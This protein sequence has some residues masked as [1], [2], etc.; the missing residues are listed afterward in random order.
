ME[1][2]TA[3]TKNV[4]R[5]NTKKNETEV[6]AASNATATVVAAPAETTT[7][8]KK[9]TSRSKKTE[10]ETIVETKSEEVATPVS[11]ESETAPVVS[12]SSAEL[13]ARAAKLAE[14]SAQLTKDIKTMKEFETENVK[15]F[16]TNF[17]KTVKNVASAQTHM[18]NLL[19]KDV[20]ASERQKQ[21]KTKKA[22]KTPSDPSSHPL[23]TLRNTLPFVTKA[24]GKADG[25]QVSRNEVQK[26][27]NQ[28]IKDKKD[29]DYQVK[30]NGEVQKSIFY[31]NK[32]ALGEFFKNIQAEIKKRGFKQEQVDM[33][34]FDKDGNLPE[35]IQYKMLM[36]YV[37]YCFPPTTA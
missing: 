12:Y 4:S 32:G 36:G 6:A 9:K 25:E 33:G 17:D 29:S 18:T 35:H 16:Y 23:N 10:T 7:T 31:I 21:K 3:T 8:E 28:L 15:E 11:A 2:Q 1:S 26:F 34:Y 37:S 14:E 20:V 30:I 13:L 22:E 27:V 19:L 24:M 5:K